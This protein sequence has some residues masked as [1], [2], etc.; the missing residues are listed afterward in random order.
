MPT[1]N[2]TTDKN[3]LQVLDK[4]SLEYVR[5]V[6]NRI[7]DGSDITE[8]E[9]AELISLEN[10]L[11][12]G[13]LTDK[14]MLELGLVDSDYRYTDMDRV[15]KYMKDANVLA[16]KQRGYGMQGMTTT[17]LNI[18]ANAS[19]VVIKIDK[20]YTDNDVVTAQFSKD[21]LTQ[22]KCAAMFNAK[23]QKANNTAVKI[24][25]YDLADKPVMQFFLN[26]DTCP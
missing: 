19:T 3:E 18:D 24:L 7:F 11:D 17:A 13:D 21:H 22:E 5:S 2:S 26:N 15:N 9:I 23:Y 4:N 1:I 16:Q 25:Y 8:A 6:H 10:D 14:E 12:L 20:Y